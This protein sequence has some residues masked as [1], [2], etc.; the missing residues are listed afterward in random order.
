MR[1]CGYFTHP[2]DSRYGGSP[3][4]IGPAYLLVIKTRAEGST[5]PLQTI[6]GNHLIQT[7]FQTALNG[8][9][10][11]FLQSYLPEKES[12]HI[13][14]TERNNLLLDVI[15]TVVYNFRHAPTFWQ[16]RCISR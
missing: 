15:K 5:E 3:D 10:I 11:T 6:T 4:G 12:S 1:T 13:F 14:L 2:T 8:T 7:N 16:S 9:E